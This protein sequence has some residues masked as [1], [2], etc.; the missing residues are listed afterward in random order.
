MIIKTCGNCGHEF[1]T[2]PSINKKSCSA[3]CSQELVKKD[4]YRKY[5]KECK[6]CGDE[7]LPPRPAEGGIYCSYK[8]RGIDDRHERVDREGYWYVCMPDH[9]RAN[10]QGYVPEHTLVMERKIGR[11]LSDDEVAHHKDEDRR[12]NNVSNLEVMTDSEHK[13]YH[14]RKQIK[15]GKMKCTS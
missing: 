7:F 6:V 14:M 9:P 11:F 12:N 3:K 2:Y 15:E 13:A 4:T 10:N 8:C 1:N 5:K